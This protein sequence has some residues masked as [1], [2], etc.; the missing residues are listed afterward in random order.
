[1]RA[2]SDISSIYYKNYIVRMAYS[3]ILLIK[4]YSLFIGAL[5]LRNQG[6]RLEE[7]LCDEVSQPLLVLL[8]IL[9]D[10]YQCGQYGVNSF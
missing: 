1:M 2:E 3:Q 8:T 10:F 9:L 5:M 4:Y 6:R 7:T